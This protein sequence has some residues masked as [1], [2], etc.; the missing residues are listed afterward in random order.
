MSASVL[1]GS[2]ID[3]FEE[4]VR[5]HPARPAVSDRQRKLTY[6]Q[7]GIM[8][9]RVAAATVVA[10]A[11]RSG[12][13]AILVPND[14]YFPAAMLGALTAGRGF[15][16]LDPGGGMER[17]RLIAM[18]SGAAAAISIS[19][20]AADVCNL[21]RQQAP[22]VMIDALGEF[23]E[24]SHRQRPRPEDLS[25]II[26][27]SG[28]TG[29]PKGVFQ[30]HRNLLHAIM[31]M[32]NSLRVNERDRVLSAK[33]PSFVGATKDILLALLNG[34]TLHMLSPNELQSSA[35]IDAIQAA[36]IT[37]LRITPTLLRRMAGMLDS[38][39]RIDTVRLVQLSAERADW[40]DFD[41][42]RRIF[43]PQAQ[44]SVMMNCT[45]GDATCWFVDDAL[46]TSG[47][48]LPVGRVVANR[49]VTI[50]D[51]GG[52]PVADGEI[53]EFVITARD[54]A[55]GYW[56]NPEAT[57]QAFFADPSDPD[58]RTYKTGD[59]GMRRSDG[60]FEHVGRKDDQ[61]KL[62]GHRIEPT[63]IESALR[64]CTG[65]CDAAIVVRK[66]ENG[67][68]RSLTA[69]VEVGTGVRD[70]SPRDLRSML[71][72]RLPLYMIPATIN[73]IE[74]L[75]RLPNLKIDREELR[76]HDQRE[77]S[78]AAPAPWTE[79]VRTK[80]EVLLL[81][82]WREV[83]D[84]HDIGYDDDF[85]LCGGDSVSAFELM[86]RIEEEF[87]WQA[88]LTILAEAPTVSQLA[89][90]LETTTL[91][92]R[93][94]V[95]PIHTAGR[96][97]ALFAVYGAGGHA[98]ALLPL[99]RSLASDQPCYW[100]QPPSMQSP[101]MDRRGAEYATLRQLAAYYI[102]QAKAVQ[103]HGPYRL[104]GN[105]F[106]G[107]VV[108]EMALQLQ[109]M[110]ESVEYLA[111]LDT[112]PPTCVFPDR[113][114]VCDSRTVLRN[115]NALPAP[116]SK[117]EVVTR[118][119]LE[120][121]VRMARDHVLDSKSDRDIFRGEL[122]YFHCTGNPIVAGRDRRR[123]WRSFASGFRL[124]PVPGIR[125]PHREPMYT[126]LR[127]LLSASLNGE[128]VTGHD[129]AGVYDRGYR[130]DERC[131]PRNI[132]GSM[133]DVYR[134]GQGGIQGSVDE[135]RIDGE[136][137]QVIGWAVEPCRRQPAQ[138]IAVF[139]DDQFLG[140]GASGEP[141][142]DIAKHLGAAS[143]LFCG[144]NF[145]FE[146]AMAANAMRRP[147]LFVLSSDG[148]AAQLRSGIEPAVI[149]ST[150]KLSNTEHSGVILGGNWSAREYW[151][152]W[153]SGH[154]ANV[155]FDASCLPDRFTIAIQAN[156]F[157]PVPSPIQ[158]VRVA[159][160]SG[161]LL[162]MLSNEQS[163]GEFSVTM[164]KAPDE[165]GALKS[166]IFDIDVPTSP[167]ELGVSRDRRKLGIGL[168]SLTFQ[169]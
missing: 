17:N 169:E 22:V 49:T 129:P 80:T 82:L 45:E 73:F 58:I 88:P 70:L 145:I 148:S 118:S 93:D 60:L 15:V 34:A 122:T 33:S 89:Y 4:V 160:E 68:V 62:H 43:P 11:N 54:L 55:L 138:T 35:F 134:V 1:D 117:F 166:L 149:G 107:H 125:T 113:V 21:F 154:R 87:H 42:F 150:K 147:R 59:L 77:R 139:L 32:T 65:V 100:L 14:S 66:N 116:V 110:G 119:I 104:L 24:T 67:V 144:F 27:T 20:L 96:R 31:Q 2:I 161:N 103:P 83:L 140:Y 94:N 123:L 167:Q 133:G 90:R 152:V 98:L 56:R 75:P 136:A 162:T 28:S 142:P 163:N 12:P 106:G 137:I 141:R 121:H 26:Y 5:R 108:F 126:A 132:L 74:Q 85:F 158:T 69:Y 46:R 111:I 72:K 157:P 153:S 165:P 120:T 3:R 155:I 131:H 143:A 76:R 114:D 61:V 51:D 91:G 146:G 16:P 130:M 57:A 112:E 30:T 81:E 71:K 78:R 52:R 38:D 164:Q 64:E 109:E 84:R 124:L 39:R 151:G 135:V 102:D 86:L 53:G 44:L 18:H 115:L 9:E 10:T 41:I 25:F 97:R 13:V 29:M 36:G 47:G 23:S 95:I 101:A 37:L 79:T 168:V 40:S 50:V 105:S 156:L 92:A 128:P 19:P 63:E 48:R 159:D 7:L 8:V 99:L 6:A 127:N